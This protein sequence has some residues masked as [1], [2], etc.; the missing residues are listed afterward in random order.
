MVVL[1]LAKNFIEIVQLGFFRTD[2]SAF[3]QSISRLSMGV[4]SRDQPAQ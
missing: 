1:S 2:V 4:A 3:L